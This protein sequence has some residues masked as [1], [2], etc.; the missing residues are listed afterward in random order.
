M[1]AL[2]LGMLCFGVG[3]FVASVATVGFGVTPGCTPATCEGT[4]AVVGGGA[5]SAL[6]ILVG[7]V[8]VAGD[9]LGG[10]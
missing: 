10:E 7:G 9:L 8:G 4:W 2:R 3:L 1:T 5:L 6:G